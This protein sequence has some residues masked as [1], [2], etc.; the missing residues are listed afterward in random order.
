M[1][2]LLKLF[3]S[4]SFCFVIVAEQVH[5]SIFIGVPEMNCQLTSSTRVRLPRAQLSSV[6]QTGAIAADAI[7]Y[8]PNLVMCATL[9]P[10]L[11]YNDNNTRVKYRSSDL[12]E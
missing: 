4:V 6:G 9:F 12:L 7:I 8:I 3:H 2:I 5:H 1:R 10:S 11:H